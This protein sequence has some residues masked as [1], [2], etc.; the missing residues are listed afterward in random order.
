MSEIHFCKICGT[1]YGIEDHHI[2]YK[3]IVKPLDKCAKNHVYLCN[4]HHRDHRNGVHFNTELDQRFKNEFREWLKESFPSEY[5]DMDAIQQALGIGVNAAR[6]L[7]KR[8]KSQYMLYSKDEIIRVCMGE[9]K[10]DAV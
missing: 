6:S 9:A 8:M 7:C 5:Y 10:E 2:V 1:S 3:S 4:T